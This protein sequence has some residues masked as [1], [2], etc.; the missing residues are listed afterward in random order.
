MTYT[1]TTHKFYYI[2]ATIGFIVFLFAW[3]GLSKLLHSSK[4][5]GFEM[6]LSISVAKPH[7]ATVQKYI[8]AVGQCTSS[9]RVVLVPQ[10]EGTL[11][12]V[13]R[14]NGGFVNAGDLL[15]KIDDKSFKAYVQQ[16]E[17]QLAIDKA[18][19]DLNLS[20]LNR[21]EG[22]RS[23]NFVSQQE[24]DSYKVNVDASK[25]QLSLDEANCLLKRIDLE[26]CT[27][28]APFAGEL[29]KSEVDPHSFITKGTHLAVLNQLQPIYVDSYLAETHL[30]ELLEAFKS[31]PES[32]S[33]EA[34]L[35]DDDSIAQTGKLTFVGN[36]IEKA[37]GTFD[38]RAQF[39]NNTLQFWPGRGIDLKIYYKTL[40]DVLLIPESAIHQGNKGSFVYIINAQGVAEMRD[41]E[42]DQT[43]DKWIVVLS[44]LKGDEQVIAGGHMLLAPGIPVQAIQ[45]IEAPK[46]LK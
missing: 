19:Y 45:T 3:H 31:H 36:E 25:A 21:S 14:P 15:F 41:V 9:N 24:Y 40:K 8:E 43:Y 46:T 42:T 34:K 10:V 22:L 29:S 2:I 27:I 12:D 6:K 30:S 16:S 32:I 18:K 20:Q 39:A 13:L 5:A 28:S 35:I 37:S 26:H 38:I 1:K 23:G 11:I 7:L 4:P 44:G 33:V 17:A